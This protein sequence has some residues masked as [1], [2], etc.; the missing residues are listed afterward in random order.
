[1]QVG[2]LPTCEAGFQ[3][4]AGSSRNPPLKLRR[5][6]NL[7][8]GLAAFFF[9][10]LDL[11]VTVF[12]L[13][14]LRAFVDGLLAEPEQAIYNPSQLA[15]HGFDGL[16]GA[17]GGPQ[18]PVLRAQLAL[19]AQQCA[20][21]VAKGLAGAAHYL[22]SVTSDD[23]AS[24]DLLFGARFSQLTKCPSVPQRLMS[25]PHSA[26]RVCA[27]STFTPS[28]P[29]RSPTGSNRRHTSTTPAAKLVIAFVTGAMLK[30]GHKSTKSIRGLN[31][32]S[33]QP[34]VSDTCDGSPRVVPAGILPGG[35]S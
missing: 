18:P 6:Y 29:V 7:Q 15:G 32:L 14:E 22:A 2:R 33:A 23:F 11:Q 1:M 30:Q 25:G 19:A 9:E 31:G 24:T 12:L 10:D 13:I 21:R 4:A 28:I 35:C 8:P 26:M 20:G 16:G 17:E 3:S 27:V 5:C 34:K